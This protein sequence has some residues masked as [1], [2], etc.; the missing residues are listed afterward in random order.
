[1]TRLV[2]DVMTRTVVV[3]STQTPFKQLVRML[4]EYRVSAVPVVGES[5]TIVGVVSEGDLLLHEDPTVLTPRFLEGHERKVERHKAEGLL[6]RDLM[7][8][9]PVTIE[10]EASTTEAAHRMHERHV[11]RLPVV[12]AD[13]TILGVISRVDLLV[14]YLRDDA[15][16]LQ[17]VRR[18]LKEEL[19]L[20]PESLHVSVEEGVVALRGQVERRTLV[21]AIWDR[22]RNVEGVVGVHER[23]VWAIDDT[24]AVVGPVPW[25]GL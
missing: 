7:T 6:A 18:I 23:L 12:D 25:V 15:E 5:G 24:V 3:A 17:E 20:E 1:M 10:P 2:R 19:L 22:V 8:S 4:R 9:P 11:K 16:I 13:G 21:P 14:E